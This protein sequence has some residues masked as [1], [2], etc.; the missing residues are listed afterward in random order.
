MMMVQHY[1]LQSQLLE[2]Q[3]ELLQGEQEETLAVLVAVQP[4]SHS[5]LQQR[6]TN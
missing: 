6:V 5:D 3:W 4:C 2:F 1:F